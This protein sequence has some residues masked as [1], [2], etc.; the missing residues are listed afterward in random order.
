MRTIL[1]ARLD[2]SEDSCSMSPSKAVGLPWSDGGRKIRSCNFGY[3]C[4][5]RHCIKGSCQDDG[6]T[7]GAVSWFPLIKTCL[8]VC[9][10]LEEGGM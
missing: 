4:V 6:H 3:Q 2:T 7:D 10:E 5:M 9:R 1:V 8:Y